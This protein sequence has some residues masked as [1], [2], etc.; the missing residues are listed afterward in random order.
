LTDDRPTLACRHTID[1][2]GYLQDRFSHHTKSKSFC[3]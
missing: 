2:R 1:S 3:I